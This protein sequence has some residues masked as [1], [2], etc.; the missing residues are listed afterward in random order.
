MMSQTVVAAASLVLSTAAFA[1]CADAG[2]SK[3]PLEGG[4]VAETKDA[5][6]ELVAKPDALYL[7]VR[8]HVRRS[9]TFG[10]EAWVTLSP[11]KS[12]QVVD[13]RPGPS[14]FE[15]TGDFRVGRGTRVVA[16]VTRLGKPATTVRFVLK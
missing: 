5:D 7:Y 10:I 11:G 9:D 4:I 3:A 16:V 8:E 14:R 1:S 13:M 12:G 6:Y 15:A 2:H